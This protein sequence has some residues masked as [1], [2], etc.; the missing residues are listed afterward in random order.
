M[1]ADPLLS[2]GI[3]EKVES[4]TSYHRKKLKQSEKILAMLSKAETSNQER[5]DINT[6]L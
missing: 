3:L 5:E 2:K 6:D 4:N 1:G